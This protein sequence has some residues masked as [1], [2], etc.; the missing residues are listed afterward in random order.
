MLY[1][2]CDRSALYGLLPKGLDIAEVGVFAG[3]NAEDILQRADPKTLFLIDA[4]EFVAFSFGEHLGYISANEHQSADRYFKAA[5]PE[6]DGLDKN[7]A[8][9]II[10]TKARERFA[11]DPRVEIR[12]GMSWEVLNGLP[13]ASLDAVYIDASH[14]FHEVLN[15]LWAA[16]RCLRPGGMIMGHDFDD[17]LRQGH[18]GVNVIEAVQQF[19]KR[20]DYSLAVLTRER[21]ATYCLING[22]GPVWNAFSE[23]LV[24]SDIDFVELPNIIAPQLKTRILS[25]GG[26]VR[27]YH[28]FA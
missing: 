1:C 24:W 10:Y 14:D 19:C 18:S 25:K 27:T 22:R 4:W 6:W 20:S 28:S 23:A 17:D 9:Q 13:E 7:T 21:S 8:L 5:A 16:A 3:D 11:H 12:R 15:D 26:R 2:S